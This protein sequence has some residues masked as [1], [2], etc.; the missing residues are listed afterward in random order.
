MAAAAPLYAG[1]GDGRTPRAGQRSRDHADRIRGMTTRRVRQTS[2]STAPMPNARPWHR[3]QVPQ[4][5]SGAPKAQDLTAAIAVAAQSSVPSIATFMEN[6]EADQLGPTLVTHP[7]IYTTLTEATD[8]FPARVE[9]SQLHRSRQG[10]M[11]TSAY[12]P[13]PHRPVRR[14]STISKDA[15]ALSGAAIRAGAEQGGG[16]AAGGQRSGASGQGG[17]LDPGLPRGICRQ[18]LRRTEMALL[19]AP[20]PSRARYR[21]H[22]DRHCFPSV[23]WR[24]G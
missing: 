6:A 14:I 19:R 12:T 17:C 16:G 22:G 9:V 7:P 23:P 3:G 1:R 11:T 18:R 24:G 8:P 21:R 15:N 13:T 5:R 20:P 4:P 2:A 10:P